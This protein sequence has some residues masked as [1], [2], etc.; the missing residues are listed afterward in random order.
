VAR[1]K[2][3]KRRSSSVLGK[4]RRVSLV[5]KKLAQKKRKAVKIEIHSSGESEDEEP[6]DEKE[7]NEV[8]DEEMEEEEEEIQLTFEG[9]YHDEC[10]FMYY[11]PPKKKRK[12]AISSSLLKLQKDKPEN[13]RM[14]N[15]SCVSLQKAYEDI[16]KR[17]HNQV[18]SI[19]QKEHDT[20]YRSISK[21]CDDMWKPK[22]LAMQYKNSRYG[23]HK[24]PTA[25]LLLGGASADSELLYAQLTEH[26]QARNE[27]VCRI[28]LQ[29]LSNSVKLKEV[30]KQ[31]VSQ[32]FQVAANPRRIITETT[33]KSGRKQK[34]KFHFTKS[35]A[36][37]VEVPKKRDLRDIACLERWYKKEWPEKEKPIILVL[38]DLHQWPPNVLQGI[39]RHLHY[40][41]K[42]DIPVVV[43]TGLT[44]LQSIQDKLD[45]QTKR[46]MFAKEFRLTKAH[47]VLDK[48][49]KSVLFSKWW[50]FQLSAR[51][52]KKLME[53]FSCNHYSTAKFIEALHILLDAHFTKNKL[54]K[55]C[56]YL[57]D[58]ISEEDAFE[59]FEDDLNDIRE[60]YSIKTLKKKVKDDDAEALNQIQ[61]FVIKWVKRRSTFVPNFLS[62]YKLFTS[63]DDTFPY[64]DELTLY[65]DLLELPP[66]E[67]I[68]LQPVWSMIRKNSP[69]ANE[70]LLRK[71]IQMLPKKHSS[72]KDAAKTLIA[73]IDKITNADLKDAT[74]QHTPLRKLQKRKDPMDR[75]IIRSTST[76]VRR[77]RNQRQTMKT[78]IL[79]KTKRSEQFSEN[80]IKLFQSYIKEYLPCISSLP[81][82]EVFCC[83]D[84]E[85]LEEASEIQS[86]RQVFEA[87]KESENM[88]DMNFLWEG[89][90][91]CDRV[92]NVPEWFQRFADQKEPGYLE[93]L[94]RKSRKEKQKM[95]AAFRRSLRAFKFM[96]FV[97]DK[98]SRKDH[99]KHCSRQTF[100]S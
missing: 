100:F 80:I 74:T 65:F 38:E 90:D 14:D 37:K 64:L 61:R 97:S 71:W 73:G 91:E 63:R 84:I 26:L 39:F 30:E 67:S 41:I 79:K 46:Q 11:I 19:V 70:P 45:F 36:K 93:N 62:F 43:I 72:Y 95:A 31:I 57:D 49:V 40:L 28:K 94:G 32:I 77:K 1:R 92:I 50:P 33:T 13:E 60:L 35:K 59:C 55:L 8:S 7:E 5:A 48:V 51:V 25:C 53:N 81:L 76:P 6:T 99:L 16:A 89:W 96:G 66:N 15:D 22:G 56:L 98:A 23:L 52:A 3:S 10:D 83:D 85:V 4:R 29:Y 86:H 24:V 9:L 69:K 87:L 58:N 20:V 47:I 54:A 78:A 44:S 82:H 12:E 17:V 27:L 18:N 21:F 75:L 34:K 88:K 68:A 42:Q 2:K